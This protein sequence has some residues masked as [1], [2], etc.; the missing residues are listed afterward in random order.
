MKNTAF[1]WDLD[2][3]LLDSYGIIVSSLHQT[4]QEFGLELDKREINK[5]LITFSL[6]VY[7]AKIEKE[8]GIPSEPVKERFS[9]INNSQAMLTKPVRHASEILTYLQSRNIP[10]Y[11]FTHKGSIT[12]AVLQNLKLYDFFEEIVT[13]KDGF[14]KK[15][16][17]AALNYLIQKHGLDKNN[18]FYVGD[19]TLDIACANN[20]GIKSIFYIPDDSY[21]VPNGKETYIVKDLLD[22]RN[23]VESQQ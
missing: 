16:D 5:E 7:L 4:Y 12:K 22:I 20:A 9:E 2:G 17:P 23:I 21:A 18:A 19:R 8:K 15:P 13:G 1:I 10:N 6:G 11:V 14:P 3:T